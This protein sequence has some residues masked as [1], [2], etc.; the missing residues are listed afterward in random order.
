MSPTLDANAGVKTVREILD[1]RKYKID[2]FQREYKW[3][4]RHIEQ[5]IRDLESKFQTQYVEGHKLTQVKDY[6]KYYMG[7]IIT[8]DVSQNHFIVDGQQ[9]L[10]SI[11]LLLIYLNN[12]QKSSDKSDQAS[13]DTLIFS[14]KFGERSYN[15]DIKDRETCMDSLY[16][17]R[18]FEPKTESDK[19]ILR[20][21]R[22]I[23]DLSQYQIGTEGLPHFIWW[24]IE[25][26]AFVEINMASDDDAYSIFETMNDRG[27]SLTPT[28]M[29]KGYLLVKAGLKAK[30]SN[31]DKNW[32]ERISKITEVGKDEDSEFFK[33]WLRGKYAVTIRP[34]KKEAAN[35]DFENIGT[36]F[37]NWVRD[38]K[39]KMGLNDEQSFY[40]FLENKFVFYS[41]LYLRIHRAANVIDQDLEHVYYIEKLEVPASFYY[42]MLMAP[43][44]IDDDYTTVNKKI[45]MTARFLE[46]FYVF[47]KINHR[48]TA[49]SSIRHTI[50]ATIKDIR[51]KNVDELVE[52]LKGKVDAIEEK[53]EG[54]AE[55]RLKTNTKKHI[56]YMLSRITSHIEKE[57][58]TVNQFDRYMSRDIDVPF[59]IEHLLAN[60]A[61]IYAKEFEDE[62]EFIEWRDRI[63]ALVLVP[64]DFNGSFGSLPY[65]KKLEHYYA[66]NLLA[67]SLNL[68]CYENNPSFLQYVEKSGLPFI[69]HLEFRKPDIE[70]RQE[71]YQ[72]ICEEIWSSDR[73]AIC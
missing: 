31:L 64:S 11:T 5:L 37:H 61:D 8:S 13:I 72:K 42:P 35:E 10:T 65:N 54:M 46:I 4:R 47:R 12:L 52:I 62:D 17:E 24:L 26:V 2:F 7:S 38:N 22:D 39:E 29:L 16:H 60:R 70:K 59:S 40:S 50:F 14:E 63:G 41:N 44:L 25:K 28:E 71:L 69:H 6:A 67:K 32:K 68:K 9:R 43:V 15:L 57:S 1:N 30:T 20:A 3:E 51:N 23:G 19:N 27:L 48:T 56:R 66:Q 53:L 45:N 36:R 55:Y 18:N 73:F 33:S 34:G 49:Y 21:Y 58:K